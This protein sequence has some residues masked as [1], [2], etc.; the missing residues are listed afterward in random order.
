[1]IVVAAGQGKTTLLDAIAGSAPP[2]A[3]AGALDGVDLSAN[4]DRFRSVLGYVPQDDIIHPELPLDRTLHYA[5]MLRL[6]EDREDRR[7]VAEVLHDLDLTSTG[8]G[9]LSGR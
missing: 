6:D 4:L 2:R 3:M 5:A 9:F 8:Q 1:M 7:G